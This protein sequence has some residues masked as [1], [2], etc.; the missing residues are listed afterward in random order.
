[1]VARGF[2]KLKMQQSFKMFIN[3]KSHPG[4][5]RDRCGSFFQFWRKFGDEQT[6][7]RRDV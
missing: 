2:Q 7:C 1:M 6:L 4:A 3:L 5:A